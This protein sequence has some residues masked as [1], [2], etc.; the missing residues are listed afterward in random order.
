MAGFSKDSATVHTEPISMQAL[1]DVFGSRMIRSCIWPARLPHLNH[2]DFFVWG[3]LKVKVYNCNPRS[4][5]QLNENIRNEIANIPA[6][7]LRT[8]NQYHSDSARNVYV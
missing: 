8:V 3:W 5:E 2:C 4:E 1:S 6:E 7:Q